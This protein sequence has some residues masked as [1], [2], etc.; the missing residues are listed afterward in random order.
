MISWMA[1]QDDRAGSCGCL[2]SRTHKAADTPGRQGTVRAVTRDHRQREATDMLEAQNRLIVPQT[3]RPRGGPW[4]LHVRTTKSPGAGGAAQD[5][6]RLDG[7]TWRLYSPRS[8]LPYQ[9]R[10]DACLMPVSGAVR[11]AEAIPPCQGGRQKAR[12][13][14]V[15]VPRAGLEPARGG[16][17][18]WSL[19]PPRL[20]VPPPRPVGWAMQDSNLRPHGCKPCAL[21]R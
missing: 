16:R 1:G 15:W 7:A 20:P 5:M 8:G 11:S 3:E 21:T 9:G 14:L 2:G 4:E 6:A 18:Q 19:S 12:R 10:R 13:G 17:P